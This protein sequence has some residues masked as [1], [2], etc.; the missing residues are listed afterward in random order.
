[1]VNRKNLAFQSIQSCWESFDFV[2][3]D[4][5]LHVDRILS[6]F[7]SVRPRFRVQIV[8]LPYYCKKKM[9]QYWL[10]EQLSLMEFTL[11]Y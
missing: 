2:K 7:E 5:C 8:M 3:D 1:M 10:S 9:I 6:T 4:I 11:E